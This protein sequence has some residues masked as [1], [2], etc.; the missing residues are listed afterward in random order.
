MVK[1][2]G[3]AIAGFHD[4]PMAEGKAKQKLPEQL[5][6]VLIGDGCQ[7]CSLYPLRRAMSLCS[8]CLY[9]EILTPQNHGIMR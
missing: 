1:P 8:K 5:K 7:E 2:S 4:D 3:I 6:Y 9:A